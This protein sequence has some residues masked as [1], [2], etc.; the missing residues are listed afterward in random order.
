MRL[1]TADGAAHLHRALLGEFQAAF[2]PRHFVRIHRS[3][4]VDLGA[5]EA[6]LGQRL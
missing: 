5:L 6:P 2:D 4:V 1:H 3:A